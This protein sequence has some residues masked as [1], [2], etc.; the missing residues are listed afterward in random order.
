[1]A[2]RIHLFPISIFVLIQAVCLFAIPE[3]FPDFFFLV[4][5]ILRSLFNP[6]RTHPLGM[7][8]PLFFVLFFKL[9]YLQNG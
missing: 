9:H 3:I 7:F 5:D 6:V 8:Y 4:V 2:P 1:M